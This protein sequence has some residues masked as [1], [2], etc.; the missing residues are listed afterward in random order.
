[1]F[2]VEHDGS[3]ALVRQLC[4]SNLSCSQP[5]VTNTSSPYR[6]LIAESLFIDLLVTIKVI[7]S[8]KISLMLQRLEKMRECMKFA[9]MFLEKN[10]KLSSYVLKP[11]S[12]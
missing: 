5:Q 9:P 11:S 10:E 1:M 8:P 2:N 6:L 7:A 4:V 12:E 3:P